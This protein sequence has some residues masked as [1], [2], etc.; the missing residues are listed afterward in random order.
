[1]SKQE[2][3]TSREHFCSYTRVKYCSEHG[4]G[5]TQASL[6]AAAAAGPSAAVVKTGAIPKSAAGRAVDAKAIMALQQSLAPV[7]SPAQRGLPNK[8]SATQGSVSPFAGLSTAF[9]EVLCCSSKFASSRR[10]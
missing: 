4:G 7:T 5:C 10:I 9:C 2:T 8:I 1:M 6:A 3:I